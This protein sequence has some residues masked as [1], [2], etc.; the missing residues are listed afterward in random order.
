MPR[1]PWRRTPREGTAVIAAL[2]GALAWVHADAALGR[3]GAVRGCGVVP[4]DVAAPPELARRLRALGL[5]AQATLAVLPLHDSQTLQ[6]EAPTVPPD[7]LRAAARWRVKDLV[8]GRL[9]D[10]MIDVMA[11][12]DDRHRPQRHLFVVAA[13]T[14]TVRDVVGLAQAAGVQLGVIDVAETAQRN[15]QSAVADAAGLAG[16]ATAALV[17]HGDQL[18]LTICA[19]GE[20]FYA[21]RLEWNSAVPQASPAAPP[22]LDD[23]FDIVDY[24][25]AAAFDDG[26]TPRLVIELQ[27]SFDVF[28]RS[29]ADLPLAGLWVQAGDDT[30]ALV[31]RL[32]PALGLRVDVLA[33]EALFPGFEAAAPE[34]RAAVLPLL[35]TLLRAETRRP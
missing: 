13:R 31:Q 25:S 14:A 9:D 2:P 1:W 20:L 22:P 6:I 7:E 10:L 17:R 21:R 28:E 18:L 8:D 33:P 16:R 27:R 4:R 11:V 29:Y 12:G 26:G 32:R 15:L 24:G 35:G 19:G 3:P 34:V 5:P 30:D 23:G